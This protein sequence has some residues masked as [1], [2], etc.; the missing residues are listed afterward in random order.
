MS[1]QEFIEILD[2]LIAVDTEDGLIKDTYT[3]DN[4][5]TVNMYDGKK[6]TVSIREN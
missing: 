3:D 2:E 1:M 6:F 4:T 5:I